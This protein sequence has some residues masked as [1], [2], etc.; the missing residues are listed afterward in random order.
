MNIICFYKYKKFTRTNFT[1]ETCKWSV[2]FT[3]PNFKM[4]KKNADAIKQNYH[5]KKETKNR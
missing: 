5:E 4:M 3:H 2:E 1:I